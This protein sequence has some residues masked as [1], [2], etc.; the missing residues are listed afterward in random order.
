MKMAGWT[1]NG[2]EGRKGGVVKQQGRRNEKE[3]RLRVRKGG[4]KRVRECKRDGSYF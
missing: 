2:G 4:Q 1:I 3:R